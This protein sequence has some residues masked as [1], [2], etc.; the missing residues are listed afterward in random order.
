M[1]FAHRMALLGIHWAVRHGSESA[2]AESGGDAAGLELIFDSMWR[3]LSKPFWVPIFGAG[4]F[5]THFRTYCI[6]GWDVHW[7][8]GVK[9]H[10][11]VSN[12]P[13]SPSPPTSEFRFGLESR[14]MAN[15]KFE[16]LLATQE[17]STV[18]IAKAKDIR[19]T[20]TNDQIAAKCG[21]QNPKSNVIEAQ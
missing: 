13:M 8:Y 7:G 10:S 4:E 16:L 12:G 1:A 11:H 20:M 14:L 19:W 9:T 3:W 2:P 5:T 6:G 21:C 18:V 15:R 17:V